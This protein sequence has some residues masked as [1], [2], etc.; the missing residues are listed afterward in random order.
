[1]VLH[2]TNNIHHSSLSIQHGVNLSVGGVFINTGE[3][4]QLVRTVKSVRGITDVLLGIS[5]GSEVSSPVRD[6]VVRV[7][8]H[9]I[10]LG[11]PNDVLGSESI[12]IHRGG[13]VNQLNV[14]GLHHVLVPVVYHIV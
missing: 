14:G 3:S 2:N 10:V 4:K 8:E 6:I 5:P 9:V 7:G 12:D 1:V 13:R 11:R